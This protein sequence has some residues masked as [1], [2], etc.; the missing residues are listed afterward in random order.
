[1]K[2]GQALKGLQ[3]RRNL[4]RRLKNGFWQ[5]KQLMLHALQMPSAALLCV[6]SLVSCG[7]ELVAVWCDLPGASPV[8]PALQ[9]ST[10]HVQLQHIS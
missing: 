2:A 5:L 10:Q 3:G 6:L 7:V 9:N 4:Q 1:M 8:P